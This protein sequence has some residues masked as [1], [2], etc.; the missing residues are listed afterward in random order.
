V[1]DGRRFDAVVFDMDGVLVDTEPA[2]YDAVNEL[3]APT[4][5]QVAWEQYETQLGTSMSVTWRGVLQMV[6]LDA[7]DV[8]PYVDGYGEVLL[9]VLRRPRPPLPGVRALLDELRQRKVPIAL[10]TSSLQD[11]VD[12][13][14]ASAGLTLA[15]FD[16]VVWRQMVERSKPAPDLYLK[17]AELLGIDPARCVAIEDTGPGVAAAKA[18]GMY[19]IQTR[20]AASAL[21]P[22][23]DA[24]LVLD[25][26]E[27]FPMELAGPPS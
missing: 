5:K 1:S 9:D 18:A 25:S 17:A 3:L 24:D 20:S 26:L 19:V 23:A 8:Q 14:F 4:G 22:L 15:T 21:P 2:F 7:K 11:W 10:A 13:I 12:A 6:G 16:A 27:D